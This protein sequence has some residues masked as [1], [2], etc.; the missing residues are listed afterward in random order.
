M[1]CC[2]DARTRDAVPGSR[3]GGAGA[4]AGRTARPAV[5]GS[6]TFPVPGAR[7]PGPTFP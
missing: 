6:L 2:C 1:W 3:K 7:C 4:I 5:P